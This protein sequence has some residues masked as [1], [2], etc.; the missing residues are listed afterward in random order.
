MP[1]SV[2]VLIV[3]RNG[4]ELPDAEEFNL[5]ASAIPFT[6]GGFAADNVQSAI[7]EASAGSADIHS[8]QNETILDE[9][10]TVSLRKEMAV[11]QEIKNSGEYKNSGEIIVGR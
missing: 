9:I 7:V 5:I 8:G 3:E 2:K 4:A 10:V 11:F 1:D 6:A